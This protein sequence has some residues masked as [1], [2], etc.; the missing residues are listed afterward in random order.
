MYQS[1]EDHGF[2]QV[3]CCQCGHSHTIVKPCGHRYCPACGHINRWRVR[4]R[5]H[6]VF[7]LYRHRQG[8]RLKMLTLAM[9]NCKD[10]EEGLNDLIAGFRRMRQTKF[11]NRH[12]IGGLFVI[13]ITGSPGSWHPHLHCF[14][15]SFRI[16][17]EQIRDCWSRSSKGGQSVWIANIT[18]DLA[19]Y[20][21]TKYVTKPGTE[22][23]YSWLLEKAVKGRRTF[24]RFG[25]LQKIKLPKRLSSKECEN[26]GCS[27]W[28]TEWDFHRL[29]L[30]LPT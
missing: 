27:D 18:N 16:P 24:Q 11:W 15:Y 12:V 23:E 14:I 29:H 5:L 1:L 22:P 9:A 10:L 25:C 7:K 13:E 17:W 21:V 2:T 3:F 30:P 20:Y 19:I 28:L 26:C 6:Q 8:Y 4:E